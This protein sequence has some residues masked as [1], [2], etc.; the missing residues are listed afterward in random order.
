MQGQ[1]VAQEYEPHTMPNQSKYTMETDGQVTGG[2]QM[3]T[4][5]PR[6]NAIALSDGSFWKVSKF[7]YEERFRCYQY[8]GHY[9]SII[10]DT[11]TV[12]WGLAPESSKVKLHITYD[13][14]LDWDE[15]DNEYWDGHS[16]GVLLKNCTPKLI[17]LQRLV[18]EKLR[19]WRL[20]TLAFAMLT[21]P[22]LG[23]GNSIGSL[24]TGDVMMAITSQFK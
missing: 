8:R 5:L 9:Y 7:Q 21:H 16:D 4:L 18:K 3:Y 14:E 24:L 6:M 20:K 13:R 1:A 17:K 15:M 11:Q 19:V 22:R 23:E 2:E 10:Y 12:F